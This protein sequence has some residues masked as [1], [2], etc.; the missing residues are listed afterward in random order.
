MAIARC[1]LCVHCSN[2]LGIASDFLDML[3]SEAIRYFYKNTIKVNIKWLVPVMTRP[4]KKFRHLL[5]TVHTFAPLTGN[6][7]HSDVHVHVHVCTCN[8]WAESVWL[9]GCTKFIQVTDLSIFLCKVMH[10]IN[11]YINFRIPH[12]NWMTNILI[13]IYHQMN[14][15]FSAWLHYTAPCT[16]KVM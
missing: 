6:L 14:E 7:L 16:Y 15:T 11:F 3:M 12:P 8:C 2:N 10:Y 5:M 13:N 9:Q 4:N 1:A